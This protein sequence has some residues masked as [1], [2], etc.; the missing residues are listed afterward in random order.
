MRSEVL[1]M[2]LLLLPSVRRE[3]H[4]EAAQ[5]RQRLLVRLRGGGNRDIE[6]ADLLDVVL[7]DLG[8]DDLLADAE[9]VIAAAVECLRAETAEVAD[10]RQRDGDQP[11]E[12][13]VHAR[14]AER[15]LCTDRHALAD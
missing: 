13:L 2:R 7:V 4:A 5:Q 9:R 3:R 8:K 15:D 10:A 12:K 6:A 1:A 11:V 14:A